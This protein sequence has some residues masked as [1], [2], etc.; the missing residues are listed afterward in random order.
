M[1][2]GTPIKGNVYGCI[3]NDKFQLNSI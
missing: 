2:I 3:R 1:F